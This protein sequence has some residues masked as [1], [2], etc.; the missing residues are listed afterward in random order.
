MIG[1][2]YCI[3]VHGPTLESN[4]AKGENKPVVVVRERR[5]PE[6]MIFCRDV[7]VQGHCRTVHK[8]ETPLPGT[9]GRAVCWVETD[10][11]III[12]HENGTTEVRV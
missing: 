4:R 3:H 12:H 1:R 11:P 6:V 8:P 2:K 9:N 7:D 5:A 10:G